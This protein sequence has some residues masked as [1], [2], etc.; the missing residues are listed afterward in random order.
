MVEFKVDARDGSAVFM[1]VNGRYWGTISLPI[2]AGIDFP[3]YHWQ[4]A[5]GDV[6]VVPND[7]AVGTHWQWTAGHVMRI[8]DLLLAARHS[9]SARRELLSYLRAPSDLS[10][11][12]A[13]MTASDPM[14]ALFELLEA[15]RYAC[16]Y[17]WKA[18]RRRFP[19]HS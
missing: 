4:L 19:P 6:P 13:L 15:L 8:H 2:F 14:P 10:A 9:S 3:L 1:E 5:H 11:C 12:D 16:D 7:Y 17:D 18:I